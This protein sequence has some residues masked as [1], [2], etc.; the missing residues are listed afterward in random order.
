[1]EIQLV[2]GRSRIRRPGRRNEG[3]SAPGQMLVQHLI[4]KCGKS[5]RTLLPP[6]QT[7]LTTILLFNAVNLRV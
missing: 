5:Y 4:L 6:R 3:S 7:Q 2:L 1:M